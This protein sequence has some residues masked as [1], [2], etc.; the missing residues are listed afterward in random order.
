MAISASDKILQMSYSSHLLCHATWLEA[1]GK[2][3]LI[4][5]SASEAAGASLKR[6]VKKRLLGSKHL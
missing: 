1:D 4:V 6:V 5:A 2:P 3:Q